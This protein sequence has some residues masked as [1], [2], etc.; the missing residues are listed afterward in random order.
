[1]RCGATSQLQIDHIDRNLKKFTL[2]SK[3]TKSLID[4]ESELVKCQILCQ[5]CHSEKTREDL[6]CQSSQVHGTVACY[7]YRG[8]R[9][10]S[11]KVAKSTYTRMMARSK[12]VR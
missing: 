4:L 3:F 1:M 11:C 8:C 7:N 10:D 6:G 2:S 5:P 12:A 9:C